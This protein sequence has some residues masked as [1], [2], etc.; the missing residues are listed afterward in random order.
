MQDTMQ[1]SVRRVN[2]LLGKRLLPNCKLRWT[3]TKA[4]PQHRDNELVK[5]P[6]TVQL[7]SPHRD[8][9]ILHIATTLCPEL[10]VC[11]KHH[12]SSASGALSSD[13]QYNQIRKD[14]SSSSKQHS[15]VLQIRPLSGGLTNTLFVVSCPNSAVPSA[16]V[17]IH[18]SHDDDDYDDDHSSSSLVNRSAENQ[19]L[20]W[21]S[22]QHPRVAPRLYGCFVNGRVEEFYDNFA[23]IH[24]CRDLLHVYGTPLARQMARFHSLP[25]PHDLQQLLGDVSC[26]HRVR[27]WLALA[28]AIVCSPRHDRNHAIKDLWST[29][30]REWTWVEHAFGKRPASDASRFADE[31]VLNHGD[32]QALNVVVH[33]EEIRLIDF[34]YVSLSPRALDLANTFCECADSIHLRANFREDYPSVTDQQTFLRSYWQ[35]L[36]PMKTTLPPDGF[37]EALQDEVG[38][39][40][41]ISHLQWSVW[42][43]VQ[44]GESDV[45]DYDY[46][47]YAKHR[48]DGFYDH[49]GR[50]WGDLL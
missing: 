2:A 30:Q 49:K 6:L 25:V 22:C 19:I 27:T 39:Y 4:V 50:F 26:F 7:H 21:L 45:T 42:A 37:F 11:Q 14:P 43:L 48:L 32:V 17:R 1:T 34:E 10:L 35:S 3:S 33:K 47:A 12:E 13:N 29:L 18:P 41:V 31:V 8:E 23:P 20:A 28:E 36:F 44:W 16:L 40:T 9:Q 15:K 38:R 46:I 24:N 5:L